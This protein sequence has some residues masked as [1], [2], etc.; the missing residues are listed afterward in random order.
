VARECFCG[1]G[2]TVPF[3]A[4]GLRSYDTRGRQV[5][6][7]L[8]W[9]RDGLGDT[10]PDVETEGWLADGDEIAAALA[11]IVHREI[12]PRSVDEREVRRWQAEGR[13]AEREI[14]ARQAASGRASRG[15]DGSA[16][17]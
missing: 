12:D 5:V 11:G 8:A 6:R 7:R 15:D 1:C 9:M 14:N 4:F 17:P 16:G 3:W 10:S 13:S 2:R